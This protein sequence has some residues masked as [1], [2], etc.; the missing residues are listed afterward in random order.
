MCGFVNKYVPSGKHFIWNA[1]AN[2]LLIFDLSVCISCRDS[3]SPYLQSLY[4]HTRQSKCFFHIRYV[5]TT[6][7]AFHLD[8]S[9]NILIALDEYKLKVL[10][11]VSHV[12]DP[13]RESCLLVISPCQKPEATVK[14]AK[15]RMTVTEAKRRMNLLCRRSYPVARSCAR[16]GYL[17]VRIQKNSLA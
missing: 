1:K 2:D 3:L 5:Q 11:I 12:Y 14:Q 17:A 6:T 16:S 15:R 10:V 7:R 4:I 13:E 9:L 8:F